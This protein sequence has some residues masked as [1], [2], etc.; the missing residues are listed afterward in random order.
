MTNQNQQLGKYQLH[1]LLKKTPLTELW[2]ANEIKHN[3]E[4][5]VRLIPSL[6]G[7]A[8]QKFARYFLGEAKVISGLAHPAI[9]PILDYGSNNDYFYIVMPYS[10]K[11]TLRTYLNRN[12]P[13][14]SW[15]FHLFQ[16]GL[17]ALS[18]AH[19]QG[20]IHRQLSPD[21]FLINTKEELVIADF[22][23]S[24]I[25]D[26]LKLFKPVPIDKTGYGSEF[27]APEQFSGFATYHSDLYSMGL[28]LFWLLTNKKFNTYKQP[29][30]IYT[31]QPS[32][33]F[34]DPLQFFSSQEIPAELA[35]FLVKALENKPKNRFA[36]AEKMLVEFRE[37]TAAIPVASSGRDFDSSLEPGGVAQ[38][39]TSELKAETVNSEDTSNLTN[40]EEFEEDF[41]EVPEEV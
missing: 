10:P 29:Y 1:C 24:S 41:Y 21:N 19:C 27:L 17:E 25:L 12:K 28:I 39:N 38:I 5:V 15:K 2:L 6:P 33:S 20:I 31:N 13:S 9:L 23:L 14:Q 30:N 36:S 18:F 16:R 3:R 32:E 40:I 8:N 34:S 37:I 4:R 35:S 7:V 22:G 26:Q 11:G